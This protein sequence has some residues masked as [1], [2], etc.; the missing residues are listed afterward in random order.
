ML[1]TNPVYVLC[2]IYV[3]VYSKTPVP[4]GWLEYRWHSFCRL[5]AYIHC[6][7]YSVYSILYNEGEVASGSSMSW[8]RRCVDQ[9][10]GRQAVYC[11]ED[12]RPGGHASAL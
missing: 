12:A 7:N 9:G 10:E 8:Y 1:S 5:T 2:G 3:N 11:D 4:S 6:N